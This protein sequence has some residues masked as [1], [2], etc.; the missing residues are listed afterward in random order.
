MSK[1]LPALGVFAIG[2]IVLFVLFANNLF[3]VG[4][5]FEDLTDAFR[6]IMTTEAIST[7]QADVAALGAVSDEF[8]NQVAPQV[9]QGLQMT[10]EDLNVFLG[11]NYPAV[12]AGVSALPDIS[13]QLT[14][15]M[16]LLADQ[17]SNFE[18]ADEIPTG[19]LP[20]T[21]VPWLIL[22]IGIGT[23]V[24][25][26]LMFRGAR[27]AWLI[28]IVYGAVVVVVILLLSFLPKSTAADDLNAALKPVYNQ[29]L[30]SNSAQALGVVSAMG[31]EMN[32]KL[33][34]DLAQQ[35][36]MDDAQMQGFLSQ[37]PATSGAL[38]NL[39]ATV[40]R[41]QKMVTAFDS[42]LENYDTIKGTSLN[43]IVVVLLVAGLLVIVCGVWGFMA[44]RKRPAAPTPEE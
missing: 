22:L 25:G 36:A 21:T 17:Q 30:V 34:P 37:F 12:A 7:A 23:L 1:R 27:F 41:F 35:L 43:P 29:E 2:I 8:A 31:N 44:Q 40:D 10:P 38:Q 39:D 18:S 33:L 42:Q 3:T 19:S 9:A 4:S 24:V 14:G 15:V 6:P 26:F 28:A 11:T 13:T 32:D 16:D 20:V 5:A